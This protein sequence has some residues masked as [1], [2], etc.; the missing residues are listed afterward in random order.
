MAVP[1]AAPVPSA[2]PTAPALIGG[3]ATLASP[4]VAGGALADQL[5]GG[6]GDD[7]LCGADGDDVL[8]GGPGND[9]LQGGRFDAGQWAVAVDAQSLVHLRYNGSSA[10]PASLVSAQLSAPAD[11]VVTAGPVPD[12]R[13]L[14]ATAPADR[15]TEIALLYH[16]AVG[17]MPEADWL[18]S[19]ASSAASSDALV[20]L[21][22]DHWLEHTLVPNA[23]PERVRGLIEQVW[24]TASDAEVQEG[25]SYL[26]HGGSWA[27]GLAYLVA[28]PRASA[29]LRDSGGELVLTQPLNLGQI[30]WV[31]GSGDD[32]LYGGPGNDVL[33]GG[34]GRNLLDGGEG[35]DLVSLV[36]TLDDCTVQ[37]KTTAPGVV[38][39]V[40][41]DHANGSE[42]LLRHIEWV[43]LGDAVYRAKANM[44]ALSEAQALPLADCVE[45]VPA[46]TL[47]LMGLPVQA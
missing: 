5:Q 45:L 39:V 11:Q 8:S 13:L 37:L 35:T 9:V 41:L 16:A 24:G 36:G 29:H 34:D 20:Q 40:L 28:H 30:G 31:R 17:V 19:T 42:N 27:Q 1:I 44:P 6:N 38:D 26:Q 25:V 2:V 12:A 3:E 21:A 18:Q 23:M 7:V 46:Q 15:L 14:V 32:T 43:R 33:V 47:T 4:V 10:A 22:T